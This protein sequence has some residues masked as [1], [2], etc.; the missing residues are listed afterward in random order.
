MYSVLFV[1]LF[2]FISLF[3]CLLIDDLTDSVRNEPV[4]ARREYAID[5]HQCTKQFKSMD[6]SH[7][8]LKLE[9]KTRKA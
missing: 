3:V 8:L 1:C 2:A 4:L 5:F 7:L 9:R 6:G